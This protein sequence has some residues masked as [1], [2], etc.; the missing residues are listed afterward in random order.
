MS[1]IL[2]Q[3][4]NDARDINAVAD[5]YKTKINHEL[6]LADG[7]QRDAIQNSWD[8]RINKKHGTD[9]ECGFSL[10]TINGKVTLCISDSGTT[11][12]NG[13]KFNNEAELVE[14]L[15][16]N[17]PGQ[18]LAYFLNSNWSAKTSEEGGNRGR[19]KT[20]FLAASGEK[21]ISFDSLRS[22]DG[23]YVFGQLYLDSDKRVTFRLHY[24]EE[25]RSV[26]KQK[27]HGEIDP[28]DQYGTRIFIASPDPLV[29]KSIKDGELL[30]FIS[31]SRWEIIK[32]FGAKIY[33]SDS[34]EKKYAT[35]SQW[36]EDN[37]TDKLTHKEFPGEIIK[38]GT[39]YKT[40]RLV[41]RYGEGLVLPESLRGIAIQRGGMTIQRVLAD[42]LVREEGMTD[43]YGWLEME[44]SPLEEELK[45]SCEGPEHIDLNW[46]IKPA[47]YL[48]DYIR[49]KVR[50]FAKE[51]KILDSEQAKVSR[52]QKTAQEEALKLLTPLFK[53]LG[54]FGKHIG[55]RTRKQSTRKE[56]EPLRLSIPDLVF[57]RDSRRVNYGEEIKGAYVIPINELDESFMVLVRTY[58][59]SSNGLKTTILQEKEINLGP[60]TG[61]KIGVDSV[62]ISKGY[63][64]GGYS[65][66][67]RMV[68]LED[69]K[70]LVGDSPIEKGTVLYERI[71]QKFFVEIDPPESGPFDF[72]PKGRKDKSYLFE[73]EAN[74]G[75][76][77][78]YYNEFHPRI[79]LLL[80]DEEKLREYLFEQGIFLA[81]QIKLE[82]VLVE[83]DKND[84]DFTRITKSADISEVWDL[85]LKRYSQFLWG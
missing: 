57:P 62:V 9:W 46:T 70:G 42:E 59:V 3:I 18:D 26:F 54:L 39:K 21:R 31:N 4:R 80:S 10:L 34:R 66:R 61:P 47:K 6:W 78:I 25:G 58:I 27:V 17:Q 20:L 73:W 32:K 5:G 41:L 79:Q 84:K 43:I 63:E 36:Y 45:A 72:Q 1:L 2:K 30:A 53:Q 67:A 56:N 38:D 8:A 49:T 11:G 81:L 28:M 33:V 65:L 68:S 23:A 13:R 40:K 24:D 60:G 85:F 7:L 37:P 16:N 74:G 14:V 50:E 69:K 75:G 48:R 76:Y 51:L 35:F 19:G 52:I 55:K 12:L 29:I 22:S 15:N 77:T 64:A 83:D 44:S 82:E 71:N